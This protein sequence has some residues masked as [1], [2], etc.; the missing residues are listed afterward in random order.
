[1]SSVRAD[2][3]LQALGQSAQPLSAEQFRGYPNSMK[4]SITKKRV[5]RP[6]TGRMSQTALKLPKQLLDGVDKLAQQQGVTRAEIIRQF[7]TE[8]LEVRKKS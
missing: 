2:R 3:V 7:L 1:M 5:G 4:P 6:A 8:A